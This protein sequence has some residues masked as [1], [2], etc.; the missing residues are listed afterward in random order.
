M[1]KEGVLKKPQVQKMFGQHVFPDL[2][3]G[4]SW[5]LCW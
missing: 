1:I 3:V 4:K 2:E 5:I